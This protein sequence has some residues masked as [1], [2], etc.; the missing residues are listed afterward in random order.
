[1]G[2]IIFGFI[3]VLILFAIIFRKY[4]KSFFKFLISPLFL[5]NFFLSIGTAVL[6]FYLIMNYLHNYTQHDDKIV[7]PNFIGLHVDDVDEFIKGKD[8]RYVVRDS[9]F[10]DEHPL[11]TVI[12][13]DPIFY[14]DSIPNYVKPNRRIYLT[15]VKRI[16]EYKVVPDLLSDNNSKA[17][18][19]AKLEMAG[20]KVELELFNHKDKDKVIDVKY[21]EKTIDKG[22]KL[23]KGSV[24]T[25]V[26]GSGAAGEPVKLPNL[27]GM[28]VIEA[29]NQL[30]LVG[31]DYIVDYDSAMTALDSMNFVVFRQDP[32]PV[33]VQGGMVSSG[34]TVLIMAKKPIIDTI[35]PSPIP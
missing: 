35:S 30:G 18:G 29:K 15:I 16:G 14:A 26:Y 20:F 31:L 10:S 19:K 3:A 6:I 34:S 7:V 23:L 27:K 33:S 2:I 1:M 9:V 24:I 25:L 21:K 32:R 12:K 11:G 5:I 17:V 4:L 28:K 13:Q 8:L 22:T